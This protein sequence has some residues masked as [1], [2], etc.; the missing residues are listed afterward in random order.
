MRAACDW[1]RVGGGER[2]GPDRARAAR[3]PGSAVSRLWMVRAG[4]DGSAG[5]HAGVSRFCTALI[6]TAYIVAADAAA[7]RLRGD[8]LLHH[9]RAF[10]AMAALSIPAWTIF[11]L[12]NLRLHNWEYSGV[13]GN[14]WVFALGAAWAFATILPAIL[15]TAAVLYHSW[16]AGLRWSRWAT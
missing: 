2:G 14:F 12:Y 6:W 15:E 8:S 9:R 3:A 5:G 16:A 13:P 11:E 1:R 7:F 10:A 4:R